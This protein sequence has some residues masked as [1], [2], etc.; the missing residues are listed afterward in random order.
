[1]SA[2]IFGAGT[3]GEVYLHYLQKSGVDVVGFLDDDPQKQGISI[4]GVPVLGGEADMARVLS[5]GV[6][7]FFCPIGHNAT[8]QRLNCKARAMGFATPNFVHPSVQIEDVLPEGRGIYILP[9]SIVMPHVNWAD[10][11][12]VSM[13]AKV[14]HHVQFEPGVFLS[15]GVSVGALVTIRQGA[16]LGMNAT[17]VTG[18]CKEVGEWAV[19]GAGSVVLADVSPHS[20]VAGV[21]AKLIRSTELR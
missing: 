9:G 18:K 6:G 13:G 15:T 19:V 5:Q 1:M 20:V 3:Y 17:L 4:L 12:M 16:Y 8:R 21:P 10:D 7:A 14:A 11:V 2:L